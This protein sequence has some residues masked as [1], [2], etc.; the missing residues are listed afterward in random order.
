MPD[1]TKS[2]CRP[3]STSA[4]TGLIQRVVDGSR[5]D[6]LGLKRG[7]TFVDPWIARAVHDR[8]QAE[9]AFGAMGWRFD[10]DGFP[11]D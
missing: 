10:R 5:A 2:R 11:A 1:N 7:P 8:G 6:P 4:L 9:V 3:V